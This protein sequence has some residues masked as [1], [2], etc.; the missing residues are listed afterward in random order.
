MR[1]VAID[2]LWSAWVIIRRVKQGWTS[3]RLALASETGEPV[4][5]LELLPKSR[6]AGNARPDGARVVVATELPTESGWQVY[7][8]TVPPDL[9]RGRVITAVN[10]QLHD[11]C[12]DNQDVV[13]AHLGHLSLANGDEIE[14]WYVTCS[15]W[16]SR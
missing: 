2:T 8:A 12:F 10:L 13:V 9:L 4:D 6:V 5:A 15:R 7:S 16:L 3:I 14:D 1:G 11:V